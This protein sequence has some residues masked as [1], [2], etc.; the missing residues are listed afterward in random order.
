MNVLRKTS[1]IFFNSSPSKFAIKKG[2]VNPDF[3][4]F[5]QEKNQFYTII[6]NNSI[7]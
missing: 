3:M 5:M 2:G 7:L 6:Y 1:L 4:T